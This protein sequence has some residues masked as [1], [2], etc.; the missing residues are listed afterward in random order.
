[1]LCPS[2][3]HDNR[4]GARFCEGCGTPLAAPSGGASPAPAHGVIHR[5][6]KPAN[7]WRAA[8]GTVLLGDFGL[9]ATTDTSRLTVDGLV[10]GTVAYLAPEQAVGRA[11]D[12]RSDLYSLGALL[13]EL[14]T[15]RP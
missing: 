8:D 15:G 13:Y 2:C 12:A 6:L 5:D 3:Q 14:V 10:I 7:V 11:P 9:A 1:M 4:G